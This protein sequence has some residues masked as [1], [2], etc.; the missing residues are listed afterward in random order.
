MLLEAGAGEHRKILKEYTTSLLD[1]L[2]SIVASSTIMAYRYTPSL[3][4]LPPDHLMMAT[5]PLVIFGFFRYLFLAHSKN[6]GGSPE[7]VFL[8]DRPLIVT[9]L[10][11]IAITAIIPHASVGAVTARRRRGRGGGPADQRAL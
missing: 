6:S 9:V 2:I 1:S 5:V 8:T 11:W 10:L 4:H 7:E 3:T